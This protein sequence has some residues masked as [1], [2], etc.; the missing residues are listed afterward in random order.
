[1]NICGKNLFYC[2]DT[3]SLYWAD[4]LGGQICK[5]DLCTN[6]INVCRIADEKFVSFI[7]PIEGLSDEFI[8]GANRKLLIVN[9]DGHSTMAHTIRTLCEVPTERVR[10]NQCK[11]DK[12][13]RLFFGTMISEEYG[14]FINLQKRAGCLY[15]YTM[16]E[17]LVELRSKIGLSN[18]IAWNKDDT[19]MFYVD[20]YELKLYE[21]DY[22][23]M[24]GTIGEEPRSLIDLSA[25][26]M[27]GK[28]FPAG[29]TTDQDDNIFITILGAGKILKYSMKTK[30]IEQ[31]MKIEA[32]MVTSCEFGGKNLED[33]YVTTSCSDIFG[34][35]NFPAGFLHKISQLN[36]KG[37][38]MTKFNINTTTV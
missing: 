4:V 25:H 28:K 26:G 16:D 17:G 38:Q 3:N 13:G 20:S 12:K 15:R 29:I 6:H 27:V 32:H 2:H 9:W 31:P 10:I 33:L 18:G 11:V 1:M 22:N 36:T 5:L 34:K 24:D 37:M 8:V 35:Q 14:S 21:F 7:V 19:K 23:A 30:K